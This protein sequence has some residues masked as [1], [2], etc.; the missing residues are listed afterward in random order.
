MLVSITSGPAKTAGQRS[1]LRKIG[2]LPPI[3]GRA[4]DAELL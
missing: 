1:E 4:N 2:A 3:A